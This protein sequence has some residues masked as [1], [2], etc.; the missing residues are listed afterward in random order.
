M[1]VRRTRESDTASAI[2]D[3]AERM[4][5]TRGFN[6]FSYADVATELGITKPALHYHFPGKAELGQ[7]LLARYTAR[8]VDALEAID[9]RTTGARGKLERYVDLYGQVL[10]QNR[11]CLCGMLAS[12]YHTL[13]EPMRLAVTDFFDQNEAWVAGVLDEG[14]ADGTLRVEGVSREAAEMIVGALEGGMLVARTYRDRHRFDGI[15]RRL[16]A[17]ITAPPPAT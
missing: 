16:L 12:D 7:A 11:M 2:L 3:V 6:A 4:V 10:A 9:A 8:F 5:Q 15:A 13:P 1:A 17:D 14:R